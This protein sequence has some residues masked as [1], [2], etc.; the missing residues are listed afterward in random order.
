[1]DSQ[2]TAYGPVMQQGSVPQ[3]RLSAAIKSALAS[4]P[5]LH[6]QASD[7]ERAQTKKVTFRQ[8]TQIID[9]PLTDLT[10]EEWAAMYGVVKEERQKKEWQKK[11]RQKKE[12]K[13]HRVRAEQGAI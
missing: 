7:G 13:A 12:K 4:R 8:Y 11:E 1:M 2:A 5:P 6:N 9:Y 10:A 3:P